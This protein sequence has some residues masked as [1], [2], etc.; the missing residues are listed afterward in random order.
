MRRGPDRRFINI[1]YSTGQFQIETRG[2]EVGRLNIVMSGDFS[3]SLYVRLVHS[4]GHGKCNAPELQPDLQLIHDSI[5]DYES[6]AQS[7]LSEVI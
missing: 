5:I 6:N 7:E 2:G 1:T 3:T 4:R